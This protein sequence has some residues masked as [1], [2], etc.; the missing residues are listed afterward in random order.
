MNTELIGQTW[1]SLGS[2]HLDLVR[3]FYARFFERFPRYRPLFP[4]D[5]SH[6]MR[7]MVDTMAM[8]SR[9]AD[10]MDV[11][12]LRMVQVGERH[13]GFGLGREDLDNFRDVFLEVLE[14]NCQGR[15]NGECRLAWKDAF[16]QVLLPLVIRGLSRSYGAVA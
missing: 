14:D 11:V 3:S 1:D 6:Q 8:V 13:G 15:W 2:A 7:K 4:A 10:S 9:L 5:M 16:D 12:E